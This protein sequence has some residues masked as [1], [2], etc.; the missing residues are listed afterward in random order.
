[1]MGYTREELLHRSFIDYVHPDFRPLVIERSA[2]R[3]RGED[4]TSR[5]EIKILTKDGKELWTDFTAAVI[6]YDG[7]P[8]IL[9]VGI[10]ITERKQMEIALRQAMEAAEAASRAK[11]TSWPT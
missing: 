3:Q 9:G 11:S 8:A 2:A 5:Y 10:D 1:M 6:E 7:K 4:V